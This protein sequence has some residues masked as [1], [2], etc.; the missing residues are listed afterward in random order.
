MRLEWNNKENNNLT[1]KE[2]HIL[3]DKGEKGNHEV[4]V[5]D[6]NSKGSDF[7]DIEGYFQS[8]VVEGKTVF[9]CN[10][11]NKGL[12]NEQEITKH[13][14]DKKI[15]TKSSWM[16]IVILTQNYMKALIKKG[17]G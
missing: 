17:T 2:T 15:I 12:N 5:N 3:N 11:D 1:E 6:E 10:I 8:E 4:S 9:V 13:I 16:I 14:K 7:V